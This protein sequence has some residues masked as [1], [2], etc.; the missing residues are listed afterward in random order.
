MSLALKNEISSI[1]SIRTSSRQT[2]LISSLIL[3][4]FKWAA[5]WIVVPPKSAAA[6]R[7]SRRREVKGVVIEGCCDGSAKFVAEELGCLHCCAL[8]TSSSTCQEH[9]ELLPS[10][11]CFEIFHHT[12]FRL[13]HPFCQGFK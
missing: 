11:H 10:S 13:L 6:R 2:A 3:L 8:A 7:P 12:I 9:D 4:L 1:I 5:L